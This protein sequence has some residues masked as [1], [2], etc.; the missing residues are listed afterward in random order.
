MDEI[1]KLAMLPWDN[2]ASFGSS[3]DREVHIRELKR[4]ASDEAEH[5]SLRGTYRL[6]V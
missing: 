3:V 5:T 4:C 1:W 6:P 2:N